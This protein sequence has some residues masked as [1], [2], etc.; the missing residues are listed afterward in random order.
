MNT[1][2]MF[3]FITLQS[4]IACPWHSAVSLD[5]TVHVLPLDHYYMYMT[6]LCIR[7]LVVSKV[8]PGRQIHVQ[9]M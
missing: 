7:L 9:S 6:T 2:M 4:Q 1:H 3:L 8:G 5:N